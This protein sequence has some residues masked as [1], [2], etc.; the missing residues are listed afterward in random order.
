MEIWKTIPNYS[1]YEASTMGRLKTFNWKNH[2]KERIMKPALDGS[3]YLRTM[4]KNDDGKIETIK[5]HRIILQT[6]IGEPF[7]NK[8][9]CNHKN[10]IRS[11]NRLINLEWVSHSEN[12]I[13]SFMVGMSSN[14]GQNNPAA[15]LTDAQVIEIRKNYTYGKK[16]KSGTTKKQIAEKYGTTFNVI[17]LLV[18]GRTW[19]HL[20]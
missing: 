2:G 18:Q 10:S 11:D 1:L 19:K 15:T 8:P 3:G 5:V 6:F 20:L 4:L 7:V 14:E 16:A 17:K 9:E 13:H 12:L